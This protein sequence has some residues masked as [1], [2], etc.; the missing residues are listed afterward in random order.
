MGPGRDRGAGADA[1][2]PD[3][4]RDRGPPVYEVTLWPNRSLT[5]EGF[6]WLILGAALAFAVPLLAF[7]GTAALW[8]M[9]PIA[10]G[11]VALLWWFV[12]RNTRDG[13][14]TETLRLWP[15]L[16]TVE[17]REPSGRVLNWAANPYW[18]R[19]ALD[20]DARIE[21]YLT[22]EGGGR[23]IELGAFLSPSERA[24]L[25]ADLEAAL[26]SARAAGPA[27]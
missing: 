10:A 16:V 24:A 19:V 9:L 20:P 18:V 13:R 23:R 2:A 7:L 15:D 11:H 27:A 12:R 6:R 17:R 21:N 5:P 26:L 1:P 8:V 22:L 14:L 25:R 3:A 4:S